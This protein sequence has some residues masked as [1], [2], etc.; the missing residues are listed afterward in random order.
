M[1]S[2]DGKPIS[3]ADFK[4][5]YVLLDFW[6]SW[7]MPCRN[8]NP[9]IVKAYNTYKDKNFTILGISLDKD[10]KAWAQAIAA[11]KLTW[12]HASELKDFEG[13]T[14]RLYQIEAIPSSFLIDPTG[15]IVAKNLRGEELAAFLEKT[16]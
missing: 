10:P 12:S 16:L 2:M 14:V 4:G 6:A 7:C 11:D 8:E 5:K 3:L 9:N 15:K 1:E 13:P